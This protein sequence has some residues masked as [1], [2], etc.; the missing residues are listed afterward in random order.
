MLQLL[1]YANKSMFL[2][3]ML[4][5]I[6][7]RGEKLTKLYHAVRIDEALQFGFVAIDLL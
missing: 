5:K 1:N 2:Q 6:E 7:R 4:R 3:G